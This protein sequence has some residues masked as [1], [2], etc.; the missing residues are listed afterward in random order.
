MQLRAYQREAVDFMVGHPRHINALP[1]GTGK[2]AISA[3]WLD[4]LPVSRAL[5]VA[6]LGVLHHWEH[7]L[8]EWSCLWPTVGSGAP[9][10]REN[11]RAWA[12]GVYRIER[13]ALI[14]NYETMRGDIEHLLKIKWDAIVFDEAHRLKNRNSQT[15]KA[16]LK[17]ARHI[18][19]LSLATGTPILNRAEELWSMLRLIDPKAYPSFWRWAE[20]HFVIQTEYF[21]S[22]P[23]PQIV[24]LKSGH[25]EVLRDEA[26]EH[27]FHRG[28]DVLDLPEVTYTTIPV[29]L[30]A[31]ERKAHRTLE[32]K[33]WAEIG[34]ELLYA[35]NAI[36]KS[37]RLRQLASDWSAFGLPGVTPS[38]SKVK[39][40]V[41]LIEDLGEPCI[42]F[43]A[44]QVTCD[45]LCRLLGAHDITWA[46]H[47][48]GMLNGQR[49]VALAAFKTG[50]QV[51]VGTIAS[52]AEGIDGLQH[53]ARHVIFLDRDWTPARNEQAVGRLHRTGQT[54][55]VNVTH[56]VATDT[57][58]EAVLHALQTKQDVIEAVITYKK[59]RADAVH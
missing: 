15:F 41:E 14:I 8:A 34:D 46:K 24:G 11:M 48:G 3:R 40:C 56:L 43:C 13:P 25:D 50:A 37:T 16:A 17:L 55:P 30:S 59:E 7:E 49:E 31:A 6:P 18:D 21:R 54:K 47:H 32:Q 4:S 58:D 29:E 20:Q 36:A 33:S 1:P 57:I 38:G 52:M 26:G 22:R 10:Q 51:L 19:Y 2:T 28:L 53:V 9:K 45:S 5:I 27:L 39:A 44:F 12:S 35:P 23:V 42:V